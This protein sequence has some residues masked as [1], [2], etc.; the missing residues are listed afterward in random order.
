MAGLAALQNDDFFLTIALTRHDGR[1]MIRVARR[2]GKQDPR[3]GVT[4]AERPVSAGA[5]RLRIA[6]HGGRYDFAYAQGARWVPVATGVDATNL[7]T[8]SAGG[9]VGTMIG[10]FAQ[11]RRD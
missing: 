8:A 3:D 5:V 10:P 9:F 2:A 11:G 6:A 4:I 1:D 7:S